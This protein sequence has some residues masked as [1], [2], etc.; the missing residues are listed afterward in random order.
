MRELIILLR[1]SPYDQAAVKD[2]LETV[3][4]HHAKRMDTV[5]D[6]LLGRLSD[7]NAQAR[8]DFADRLEQNLKGRR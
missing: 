5:R 1:A 2:Q 8:N 3:R 4:S 6:L 7:M